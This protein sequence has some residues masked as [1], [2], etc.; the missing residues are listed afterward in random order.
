MRRVNL[1]L[2]VKFVAASP[3]KLM[4]LLFGDQFFSFWKNK[5]QR[6]NALKRET[7]TADNT[8]KTTNNTRAQDTPPPNKETLLG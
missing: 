8:D 1:F 4:S 5:P 3:E 7:T 6:L 2:G